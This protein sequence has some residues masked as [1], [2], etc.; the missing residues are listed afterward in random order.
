MINYYVTMIA[1]YRRMTIDDVPLLWRE[2]VR[3][4][5]E[6]WHDERS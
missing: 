2:A 6:G 3:A 4:A 1:K 5:L